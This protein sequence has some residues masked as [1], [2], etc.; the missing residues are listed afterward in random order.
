ME[1]LRRSLNCAN[2]FQLWTN[3]ILLFECS[4]VKS[5]WFRALITTYKLRFSF[6]LSSFCSSF[7][8]PKE[9]PT[10]L[11][12]QGKGQKNQCFHALAAPIP[13]VFTGQR[14]MKN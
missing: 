4:V 2:V 13:A 11:P 1:G 5:F 8:C 10:C 7:V 12:Q 14:K 6:I 3:G 9:E